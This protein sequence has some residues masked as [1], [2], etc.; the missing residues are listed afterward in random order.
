MRE[1]SLEFLKHLVNERHADHKKLIQEIRKKYQAFVDAIGVRKGVGSDFRKARPFALAYAMSVLARRWGCLPT[2]NRV[3]NY[4]EAFKV[5]WSW[6]LPQNAGQAALSPA[7][8]VEAYLKAH[9]GRFISTK[10]LR[11]LSNKQFQSAAGFKSVST[12]GRKELILSAAQFD[13][14]SFTKA[15]LDSLV[16][17]NILIGEKGEH[18]RYDNKRVVRLDAKRKPMKERVFVLRVNSMVDNKHR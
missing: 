15:Q 8:K 13:E 1:S 7:K 5:V 11:V 9:R 18:S 17:E 16:T 14:F 10:N 4:L 2:S 12:H 6:T 3:G